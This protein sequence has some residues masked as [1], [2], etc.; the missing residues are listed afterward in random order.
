MS[1]RKLSET[2]RSEAPWWLR[3]EL[4]EVDFSAF[5]PLPFLGAG[6][7]AAA[8]SLEVGQSASVFHSDAV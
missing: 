4:A 2:R 1:R 7:D 6:V 3:L 8:A 5:N